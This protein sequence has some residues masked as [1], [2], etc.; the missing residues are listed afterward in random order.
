MQKESWIAGEMAK[1]LR[2]ESLACY[3]QNIATKPSKAVRG[4]ATNWVFA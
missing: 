4:K 1:R 2:S 3:P